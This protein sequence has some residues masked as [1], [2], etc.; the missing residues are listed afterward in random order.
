MKISAIICEFNPFHNG[1][2]YL[3]SRAK[4]INGCNKVV[5]VMSGSF[6]QRGDICRTDKYLR[7]KH[8]ILCGADAVIEL[9]APFAVAPAEIFAQGAV[10]TVSAINAQTTIVFGCESCEDDGE[11]IT[12]AEILCNESELFKTALERRLDSGESY[13]KSYAAAYAECGGNPQTLASP[14]NILGVEYV[15]AIARSAK[16][17]DFAPVKR[18][19][20]GYN[21]TALSGRFSSASGIRANAQAPEIKQVMPDCSYSDFIKSTDNAERFERLAAD[22]LYLCD[23]NDLK[24][25]YGCT[26]GLENRLKSLAFGHSFEEICEL[27]ATKRYSKSRIRRIITANILNLYADQTQKFLNAPLPLK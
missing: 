10:K 4:E 12:A 2:E 7:A 23:K 21:D 22:Y 24:R 20:A 6:T 14:N 8:A 19:G 3:I 15:K 17:I 5:C 26:E 16:E 13:I 1:H 25:V 18:V 11:F 27:A 9:P